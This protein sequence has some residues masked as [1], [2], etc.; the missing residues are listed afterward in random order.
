[1]ATKTTIKK[2]VKTTK[3]AKTTAAKERAVLVCTDKRGVFF[4]YATDT[5]GDQITLHRARNVIYWP[6]KN[7][8]FLGLAEAGPAEG[9]RVGPSATELQLRGITCVATCS[10]EAVKRWELAPWA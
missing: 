2:T 10:E 9:S 8:G 6:A 7:K 5:S 4:G 3:Q 1:M